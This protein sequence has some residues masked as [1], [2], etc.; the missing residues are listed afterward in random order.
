MIGLTGGIATGKSTV[1][2]MLQERGAYVLDADV[3]ARSVIERPSKGYRQ[4][5]KA[6]PEAVRADGS[7]DRK[8]LG[9]IIFNSNER[10]R[11]L[12]GIIHPLVIQRMQVE[13]RAAEQ[14]GHIVV[15][16][17]PLLFE[18]NCQEWLDSVWVVYTDP[19]VQR[20][21]LLARD[22]MEADEA[23]RRI[24]A[25]MPLEDKRVRADAVIDNSDSLQETEE[26]VEQLWHAQ[27]RRRQHADN[28]T[29]RP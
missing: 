7:L 29:H 10:R 15:C 22:G 9:S 24:Q 18:T 16:D 27:L 11:V 4:V 14:D 21:R 8:K 3:L 19:R 26:Q 23:E 25:Q 1:A 6:F 17:I 5:V 28:S 20:Q 12:E 2:G 13:G